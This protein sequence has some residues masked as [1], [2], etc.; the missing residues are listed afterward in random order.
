MAVSCHEISIRSKH[1]EY[2]KSWQKN[3]NGK[4]P[5]FLYFFKIGK[6]EDNEHN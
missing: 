1:L 4:I 6:E 3:T 2:E 5:F